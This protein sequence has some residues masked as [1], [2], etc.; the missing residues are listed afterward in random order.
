MTSSELAADKMSGLLDEWVKI[1]DYLGDSSVVFSSTMSSNHR[2]SHLKTIIQRFSPLTLRRHFQCWNQFLIWLAPFHLHVAEIPLPTLLDYL[3]EAIESERQSLSRAQSLI[4][5]LRFITQQADITALRKLLWSP[6]INAYLSE[7]RK[8]QNPRETYP[9]PFHFAVGLERLVCNPITPD[10]VVILAGGLLYLLWS[11][12]RFQDA[13]RTQLEML[14]LHQGVLRSVTGLTKTASAVPA[15][16]FACGLTSHDF[17]SGWGYI[18]WQKLHGWAQEIKRTTMVDLDFIFPDMY[19]TSTGDYNMVARPLPYYKAAA[20]L[21]HIGGQEIMSPPYSVDEVGS[22]TVHSA[23]STLLAAGKALDLPK[24]WLQEQGH[25]KTNAQDVR[26]GRD[27]TMHALRLQR[28]VIDALKDG[29][30]PLMPQ[31]R[32]GQHPIPEKELPALGCKF[33]WPSFVQNLSAHMASEDAHIDV[34]I[35]KQRHRSSS[36]STSSSSSSSKSRPAS[37]KRDPACKVEGLLL[38]QISRIGHVS[39]WADDQWVPACG[40]KISKNASSLTM[41]S[42]LPADFELCQRKGC[43]DLSLMQ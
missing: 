1:I 21:R 7:G 9:L 17:D 34:S 24:H 19:S 33:L 40:A 30:R 42:T 5:S 32:G 38:N 20:F 27:D 16:A 12:L 15:A 8:P 43:V 29:W 10:S 37:P 39:I 36:S 11:G 28:A 22:L 35:P 41:A 6:V 2:I 4:K 3:F 26:Y 31:A 18:W 14:S 25:H 13:Q 23:K